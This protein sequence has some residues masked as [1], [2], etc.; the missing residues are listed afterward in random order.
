MSVYFVAVAENL[1]LLTL[2]YWNTV[3]VETVLDHQ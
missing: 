3:D 1:S 2:V